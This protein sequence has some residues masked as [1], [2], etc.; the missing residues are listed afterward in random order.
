MPQIMMMVSRDCAKPEFI[1]I[2]FSP[3]KTRITLLSL[4]LA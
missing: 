1:R 3:D 4:S 2:L